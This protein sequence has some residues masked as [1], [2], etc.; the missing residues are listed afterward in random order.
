VELDLAQ[1][2]LIP[3]LDRALDARTW[4]YVRSA[5]NRLLDSE[6]DSWTKKEVMAIVRSRRTR[7][8]APDGRSGSIQAGGE[9]S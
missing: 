9:G 1:H 2:H 7:I 5:I 3:D 4:H 6:A 8:P